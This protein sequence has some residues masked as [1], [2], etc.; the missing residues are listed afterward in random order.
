VV[1]Y[2][3]THTVKIDGLRETLAAFKALPKEANAELRVETLKL[4]KDLATAV[5]GAALAEG[6]QWGLLARTVRARKDRVPVVQAGGVT[7]LG[8]NRKPAF[9][10]LFGAEFGAKYLHQ[11]KPRQADGY[12]FFPAADREVPRINAAWNKVA[13]DIQRRFGEGG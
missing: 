5:K 9:K 3:I 6:S 10:L 12:V 11:F 1:K 4:S 7:R 8:R 2:G 13:D